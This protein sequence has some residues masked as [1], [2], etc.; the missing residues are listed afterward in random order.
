[1]VTD[2]LD[3]LIRSPALNTRKTLSVSNYRKILSY[4]KTK[5][6]LISINNWTSTLKDLSVANLIQ[7]KPV[8]LAPSKFNSTVK[9]SW[10]FNFS[11]LKRRDIFSVVFCTKRRARKIRGKIW[12]DLCKMEIEMTCNFLSTVYVTLD[13]VKIWSISVA[14]DFFPIKSFNTF[15]VVCGSPIRLTQ[16]AAIV[17]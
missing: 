14:A 5:I 17:I 8:A 15:Q 2:Y 9:M 13:P 16:L 7:L 3:R 12:N 6:G 1:M 11:K 10:R 4:R